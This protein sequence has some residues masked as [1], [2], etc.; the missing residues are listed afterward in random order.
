MCYSAEVKLIP[1]KLRQ[2]N[3]IF[4]FLQIKC[5]MICIVMIN[6]SLC[7]HMYIYESVWVGRDKISHP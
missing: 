2:Y 5:Y 3:S 7:V 6:L 4:P 1:I